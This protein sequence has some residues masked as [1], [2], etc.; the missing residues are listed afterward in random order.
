MPKTDYKSEVQ[1]IINRNNNYCGNLYAKMMSFLKKQ[2]RQY[3]I[4]KQE[5]NDIAHN[6]ME[7]FFVNVI[8]GVYKQEATPQTYLNAIAKYMFAHHLKSNDVTISFNEY[9][10]LENKLEQQ[11]RI[12]FDNEESIDIES[13][14]NKIYKTSFEKLTKE[15]R[16]LIKYKNQNKD[17]HEIAQKMGYT[18]A[19]LVRERF[20]RCKMQLTS[21]VMKNSLYKKHFKTDC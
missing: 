14:K 21:L 15:C 17:K 7:I 18:N 19:E 6:A 4:G 9:E 20:Y 10:V 8:N 11:P 5:L 12:V 3:K 16:W 13:I 2:N 1:K